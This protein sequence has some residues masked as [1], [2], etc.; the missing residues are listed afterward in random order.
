MCENWACKLQ[1][2]TP[3][4]NIFK[5]EVEWMKGGI[6]KCAFFNGKLAISRK[7]RK[8]GPR[9]LLI[10]K[11]GIHSLRLDGNHWPWMILK[12]LTTNYTVNYPIATSD[13]FLETLSGSLVRNKYCAP[14]SISTRSSP[15]LCIRLY[16]QLW[17]FCAIT[18]NCSSYSHDVIDS[19]TWNWLLFSREA[20]FV[21]Q[22]V[23]AHTSGYNAGVI[24][25]VLRTTRAKKASV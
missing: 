1:R 16:L 20:N 14:T 17:A 24:Y 10:I 7:R 4:G 2:S 12:S 18:T 9:L 8:T 3:K 6:E 25:E 11:S 5:L 23:S 19:A 21:K 22:H 13:C 15:A